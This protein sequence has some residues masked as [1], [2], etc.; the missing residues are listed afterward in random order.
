MRDEVS[1]VLLLSES[2]V[3]SV[4]EKFLKV[5]WILGRSSWINTLKYTKFPKDIK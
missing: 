1:I 5:D 3:V 2:G 4:E